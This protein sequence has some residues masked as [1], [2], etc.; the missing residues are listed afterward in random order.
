MTKLTHVDGNGHARMVDIS[1]KAVTSRRAVAKGCILLL[2]ETLEAISRNR[3]AKGDVI[4]T[5]RIAGVMAAKRCDELIPLCHSLPLDHVAVDLHPKSEPPQIEITA[6]V[7]CRART[8][9]E[10][11]ALVAVSAAALTVYDMVKA[12]D[13]SAVIDDIRL[14]EKSGGKSGRYVRSESTCREA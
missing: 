3:I 11:E 9:A 8:G 7:R 1:E 4:A 5:A 12:I 14:I 2:P 13:R 10:M 6:E